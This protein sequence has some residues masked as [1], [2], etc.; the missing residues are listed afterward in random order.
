MPLDTRI[1]MSFVQ[2]PSILDDILK[3]VKAASMYENLLT[4]RERRENRKGTKLSEIGTLP[5]EQL[6]RNQTTLGQIGNMQQGPFYMM[7]PFIR[8]RQEPEN[9]DYRI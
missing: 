6:S 2:G 5:P 4:R 3:A 8:T 1:P 9:E 7:P